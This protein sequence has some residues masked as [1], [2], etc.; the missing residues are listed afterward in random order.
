MNRAFVATFRG[1]FASFGTFEV[2]VAAFCIVGAGSAGV[3]ASPSGIDFSAVCATD[4]S[5]NP[6]V[7]DFVTGDFAV[8]ADIFF[9]GFARVI[10]VIT[11]FAFAE[12]AAS[13]AG[14]R[15]QVIAFFISG[16]KAVAAHLGIADLFFGA[17]PAGF[18]AAGFGASIARNIIAVFAGL[19]AFDDA[20]AA[21]GLSA[22]FAIGA[23]PACFDEA[24]SGTSVTGLF[25][26]VIAGFAIFERAV[27]AV[28]EIRIFNDLLAGIAEPRAV[29]A[30][31]DLALFGTAVACD[32]VAVIAS[33]L[34]R[35]LHIAAIKLSVFAR[36]RAAVVFR[37]RVDAAAVT[38]FAVI[39]I[40]DVIAA[41]AC[42]RAVLCASALNEQI[43]NRGFAGIAG[44]AIIDFA[45]AA[46]LGNAGKSGIRAVI[47]GLDLLAR[48]GAS[49]AACMV[50]VITCFAEIEF[51]IAAG[52][53]IFFG[54]IRVLGIA[55]TCLC[56]ERAKRW[57]FITAFDLAFVVAS[58]AGIAVHIIALF[59]GI[60]FAVAAGL[61]FMVLAHDRRFISAT[62]E[63]KACEY[64]K[65]RFVFH[66]GHSLEIEIS[67]I[68]CPA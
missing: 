65:Y 8:T 56:A 36:F 27:S 57:A 63:T 58:V 26:A 45:I 20:V 38:G 47:A 21:L 59:A 51:S 17:H 10:A 46:L 5:G 22:I 24:G 7:A 31:F 23:A 3:F 66:I 49:V 4:G 50:A 53:F 39:A 11:S 14:I 30:R 19:L 67:A 13:I 33:F 12:A 68:R 60:F 29:P 52:I 44:F 1:F 32:S 62:G 41:I 54:I 18:N 15:I 43:V 42:K 40:D 9:A 34:M 2:A 28:G 37:A 55:R 48:C 25:V 16:N 6:F 35:A 61:S 64:G